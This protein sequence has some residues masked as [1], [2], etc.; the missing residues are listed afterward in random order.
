MV[1]VFGHRQPVERAKENRP[2]WGGW[3][4]F[5][6]LWSVRKLPQSVDKSSRGLYGVVSSGRP[7]IGDFIASPLEEGESC[8]EAK[9]R[10]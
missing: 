2:T 4:T 10:D 8:Q 5:Y 9:Q 6:R 1:A 7:P 3:F